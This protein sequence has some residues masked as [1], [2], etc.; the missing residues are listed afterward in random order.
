[1]EKASPRARN[2]DL[3]Y[4]VYETWLTFVGSDCL[5]WLEDHLQSLIPFGVLLDIAEGGG[6]KDVSDFTSVRLL[7]ERVFSFKKEREEKI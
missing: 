2:V 5:S 4:A 6:K 1:M 3:G 7:F